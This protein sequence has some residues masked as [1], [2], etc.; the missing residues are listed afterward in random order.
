M[1]ATGPIY[2]AHITYPT[3]TPDQV[4]NEIRAAVDEGRAP[5]P[6]R[7]SVTNYMPFGRAITPVVPEYG[8]PPQP[9]PTVQQPLPLFARQIPGVP[10][11]SVQTP[12]PAPAPVPP[13]STRYT[14]KLGVARNVLIGG[15]A[16]AGGIALA[17]F[18][19]R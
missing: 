14:V 1:A 2:T 19:F 8:S 17:Y 10:A 5:I 16:I 11:G 7:V 6:L 13:T 15:A 4:R 9:L 3:A 18:L 12:A